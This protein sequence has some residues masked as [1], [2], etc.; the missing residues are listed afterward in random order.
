M[1]KDR[2]ILFFA[3]LVQVSFVAMNVNFI[4]AG[5]V[6]PMLV[7]SFM[8]SLVWTLNVQKISI[9]STTDRIY[10]ATG[11]ALGTGIGYFISHGLND[12]L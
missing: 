12:Y 11:A 3:A 6:I 9:G 5:K 2:V 1:N 7:T 4:S 10:Y 8:V